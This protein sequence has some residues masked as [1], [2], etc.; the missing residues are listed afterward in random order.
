MGVYE[1][2]G[3]PRLFAIGLSPD[4]DNCPLE[5]AADDALTEGLDLARTAFEAYLKSVK[6]RELV[7]H[8]ERSASVGRLRRSPNASQI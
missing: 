7:E 8:A 2:F 6:L 3:A 4:A 1:A 5:S